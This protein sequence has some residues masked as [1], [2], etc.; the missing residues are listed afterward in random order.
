MKG[1]VQQSAVQ[2]GADD[3]DDDNEFRF[4]DVSTQE[5]HLRQNGILTGF[6]IETAIMISHIYA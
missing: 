2:S 1:T 4:N 6:G 3:D 5:G